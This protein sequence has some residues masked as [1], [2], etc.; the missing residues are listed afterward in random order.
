MGFL[1]PDQQRRQ[2]SAATL[3]SLFFLLNILT[4]AT[5]AAQA[6]TYTVI[7]NFTGGGDGATPMA[8]LTIDAAGNLYGTANYGGN[9]G[10]NCGAQGCGVVYRLANRSSGWIL[11]PLYSFQGGNDGMNPEIANVVI[12]TD[13]NLYSTTYYGGG[14]CTG[15]DKGCGTVFKLQPP[16]N[17]CPRVSCPWTETILQSFNGDDGLGPVGA[18]V[19]DQQG[20]LDGVT[21]T[22]SL[23]NGGTVY[24]LNGSGD[25]MLQIL[26]HPYGYPGSG[27]SMDHAGN[28]YG[29]TFIGM[30]SPGT[31]YELTPSGSNWIGTDI[32]DFTGGSDGSHPR[33]GVIL[34]SAGNL[35]GATA[36]GGSGQGGTV[37]ELSPANG[38]WSFSLLYS[39]TGSGSG[40]LLGGPVGNLV[41]DAAGNL[42]GTTLID[43]AN[44]YGA[45][46]KLTHS[47]TGWSYTSLHDFTNGSDGGTPYSNLIF[48]SS[49]TIYG[50]ASSGGSFGQ[51]VVFQIRP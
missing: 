39:F 10:D 29:S 18:L 31:I 34:D 15:S 45:V 21:N 44:G 27:V 47:E 7:H 19:F 4:F 23:R 8:G 17:A 24:Q 16:A 49:G 32:Y 5:Q 50:T 9:F 6:Q 22:G 51:G 46:F 26:F 35:Y 30:Q 38:G 1:R 48:D 11:T 20:N 2:H 43:G 36:T 33:A 41:M 13:G 12:G 14:T 42:Y 28:L 37:F 25:N 3:A 40:A